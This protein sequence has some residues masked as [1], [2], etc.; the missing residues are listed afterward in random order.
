MASRSIR[1]MLYPALAVLVLLLCAFGVLQSG[2]KATIGD[3]ELFTAHSDHGWAVARKSHAGIELGDRLIALN[4]QAIEDFRHLE[5]FLDTHP[6]GAT[7]LLDLERAG[8]SVRVRT[9]LRP[10]YGTVDLLAQFLAAVASMLIGMFV[11][12]RGGGDPSAPHF[13]ALTMC[14]ACLVCFTPGYLYTPP[15][16]MG[17]VIRALFPAMYLWTGTTLLHFTLRF[18]YPHRR[19]TRMQALGLH[20]PAIVIS[21]VGIITTV[22]QVGGQGAHI[23]D[24]YILNLTLAKGLLTLI[25]IIGGVGVAGTFLRTNDRMLR[26]RMLWILGSVGFS[27]L[28]YVVFW[29]IP[30][31]IVV[32]MWLPQPSHW[33]LDRLA[34]PEA[35]LMFALFLSTCGIAIG[36]I[37]YR[38]FDIELLLRRSLITATVVLVILLLY[39]LAMVL[40]SRM[41]GGMPESTMIIVSAMVMV[42][43]LSLALPLRAVVQRLMNR[44]VFHV[45][46]EFHEAHQRLRQAINECLAVPALAELL[47]KRVAHILHVQH[48]R[49]LL[50]VEGERFA[51]TAT[52]GHDE[53]RHLRLRPD[54]VDALPRGLVDLS[55]TCEPEARA[56]RMEPLF[57]RRC[58]IACCVPLLDDEHRIIGVLAVGRRGGVTMFSKEDAQFLLDITALAAARIV[59]IRLQER[60]T[61]QVLETA[62]LRE[63]NAMKSRFVSGVGHDLKTPL[64]AIRMYAEMIGMHVEEERIGTWAGVI[65]GE[66]ER[67][68]R[69]IDN[70]LHFARTEHGTRRYTL[71]ETDLVPLV[72]DVLEHL[73]YHFDINGFTCTVEHDG[74][75]CPILADGEALGEAL[76]NLLTNAVKYSGQSRHLHVRIA[77]TQSSCEVSVRDHGLGI[78]DADIRNLFEPFYRSSDSS[79]QGQGGAGLGLS[80]VRDIAAAHGAAILVTSV[81][82]EGSTFT[83]LVPRKEE[84]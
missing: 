58:N 46:Q 79:V 56:H 74:S 71:R 4:G 18:R 28:W 5:F 7:V 23:L 29:Q 63:L 83:L 26:R 57:A 76:W 81:P 70:V 20:S 27:V 8:R 73:R 59:R 33:I 12:N 13:M 82:G 36:I 31:S 24:A 25:A 61:M 47:A 9:T 68:Q 10:F 38:L 75:P 53:P 80:L 30:R 65:E 54:R 39:V 3:S 32:R 67:L 42:G 16:G 64:T 48:V 44:Y 21:I 17:Y 19:L 52:P 66:C 50:H 35:S 11:R 69:Q 2:R 84:S 55:G 15:R 22:L 62:R 72:R 1:T 78:D 37:R 60:L 77:A 51:V 40:L 49:L 34:L 41:F 45:E 6:V 14:V 43:L